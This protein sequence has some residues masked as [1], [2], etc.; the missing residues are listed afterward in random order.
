LATKSVS[1]FTS[2]MAAVLPSAADVDGD[3]A[4]GGDAAGA[5]G[6]LVAE[7]HAQDFLGLLHVAGGFGEGLLAVHHGGV[8]ALAQFFDHGCGDFRHFESPVFRIEK[9]PE[10]GA[11]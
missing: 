6:G 3:H 2:T 7:A 8:G 11:S 4:F 5:L 9:R 1:Q 10:S